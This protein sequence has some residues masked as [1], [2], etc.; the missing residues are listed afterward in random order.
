[1]PIGQPS[2]SEETVRLLRSDRH[3]A[4]MMLLLTEAA[5]PVVSDIQWNL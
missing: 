2:S 3:I 5:E 4:S 1:M